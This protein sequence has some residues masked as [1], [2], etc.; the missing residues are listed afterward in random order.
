MPFANGAKAHDEPAAIVRCAALVWMPHDAWIEQ[1]RGFERVFAEK[2]SPDQSA[3]RLTQYGV[4]CERV[5][6]LGGAHF[7][8]VEQVAV[9]ACEIIK[10]LVQLLRGGDGIEPKHP[11]NDMIGS[12]PVGRIEIARLSRRF[13]GPDDDPG[14]IRPQIEAL[15]IHE[16]GLGQRCSLEAIEPDSCRCR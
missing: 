9:A 4:R 15:T 11:L 2:I 8:D 16:F 7:K 1:G 6:H 3:L 13:E 14:R 5:L 12:N 10:H